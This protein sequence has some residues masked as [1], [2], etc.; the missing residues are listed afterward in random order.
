MYS[1]AECLRQIRYWSKK[2]ELQGVYASTVYAKEKEVEKR[3][4]PPTPPIETKGEEKECNY[5]TACAPARDD[6]AA[7]TNEELRRLRSSPFP[8]DKERYKSYVG[9]IP[10]LQRA[11]E[12]ARLR[13][14]TD[15][16]FVARWYRSMEMA[17]WT[18]RHA[19]AIENW[20]LSLLKWINYRGLFEKLQDPSR[21]PDAMFVGGRPSDKPINWRGAIKEDYDGFLA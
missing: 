8:E 19:N 6:H 14:F 10:T 5:A 15:E 13:G 12:H 3:D 17:N 7:L 9:D 4:I 16:D 18:D 2:L 21:I 1:V 20:G 11:V